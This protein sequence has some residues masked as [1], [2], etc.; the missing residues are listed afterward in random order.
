MTDILA[1]KRRAASQVSGPVKAKEEEVYRTRNR[2][3]FLDIYC[4]IL[5]R[6][7]SQILLAIL[8]GMLV[9]VCVC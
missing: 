2:N 4:D 7:Y 8:S 3:M 9:V 5:S 6:K 1:T